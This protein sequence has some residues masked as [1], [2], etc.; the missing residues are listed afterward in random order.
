[1]EPMR[2]S[3]LTLNLEDSTGFTRC[4]RSLKQAPKVTPCEVA[5]QARQ[6]PVL[7]QEGGSREAAGVVR[8][9]FDGLLA[10]DPP[11]RATLEPP[12]YCAGVYKNK[13]KDSR[14]TMRKTVCEVWSEWHSLQE[15]QA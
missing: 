15:M 11:A 14:E 13:N 9:A 2:K 4:D 3:M 6:V 5:I 8:H 1:M 7:D 12:P 10:H